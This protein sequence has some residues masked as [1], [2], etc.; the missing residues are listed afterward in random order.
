MKTITAGKLGV[1]ICCSVLGLVSGTAGA[2]KPGNYDSVYVFGD[3]LSDPGN[4]YA[5]S[6]T[7]AQPPYE[8]IPSAPYTVGGF[9]FTNGRTWIEHLTAKLGTPNGG[10]PAFAKPGRYGNYAIG[11]SRAGSSGSPL[12]TFAG[13]IGAFS[14]DVGGNAPTDAL[15]VVAFGGNDIRDA[16]IAAISDPTLATSQAIIAAAVTAEAQGIAQ[17]YQ[18]GARKFLVVNAPNVAVTPIVTA[19]GPQSVA[20]A[21][22][23]TQ[24]FNAGLDAALDGL[25]LSLPGID[26]KRVDIFSIVSAI[27]AAPES[28]GFSNALDTC[29]TFGVTNNVYCAQRNQYLFWDSVHPTAAGH[30]TIA[31]IILP[32]VVGH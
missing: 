21:L 27:V 5:L 2:G 20:G 25:E 24:G 3:S 9:H 17:L 11:G 26:I 18:A 19:Q 29:I 8:I 12:L 7:R 31:E 6:G 30:R 13:Q 22:L 32:L 1:V 10:K 4:A 15:Y 28:E 23:L 14:Q 16:L